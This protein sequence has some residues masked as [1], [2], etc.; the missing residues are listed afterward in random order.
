M[1]KKLLDFAGIGSARLHLEWVSSAEAQRFARITTDVVNTVK[2]LGRLDR[3]SLGFQLEAVQRT[4]DCEQ[5]RWTVGK[6][7]NLLASGDVYGRK[8]GREAYEAVL[9]SILLTEY[10]KNLIYAALNKG[11]GSV[12]D[13][14]AKTGLD[15][16]RISFLLAQLE[17]GGQVELQ[18][19]KENK[20]HFA[21]LRQ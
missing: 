3:E 17:K 19:M 13:I 18:S 16:P 4:L 14:A 6:E 11:A 21:V 10:E 15:L 12:R 8:W 1:T 5:I 20:P 9:D 7:K 2:D